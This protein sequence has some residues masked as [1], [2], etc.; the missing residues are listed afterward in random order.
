MQA[1]YD[2]KADAMSITLLEADRLRT[3]QV[4]R[5]VLAHF[6]RDDRLIEIEIIGASGFYPPAVLERLSSPAELL[7]L[8]DAA[9]EFGLSP[10]TLRNQVLKG[11]IAAVKSGRDWMVTRAVMMSYLDNRAPSGRQA[12][13]KKARRLKRQAATIAR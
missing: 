4:S 2:E 8:A 10:T 13:R 1:T 9:K 3:V 5:G 12:R 7:T 11:K 6:D